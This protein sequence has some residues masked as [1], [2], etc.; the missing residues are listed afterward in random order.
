MLSEYLT[1]STIY[2][3]SLPSEVSAFVQRHVGVHNFTTDVQSNRAMLRHTLFG[4]LGL[5]VIYYGG[6]TTLENPVG[7]DSFHFQLVMNGECVIRVDGQ[8]KMLSAGC[9]MLMNPSVPSSV[10]Y[11]AD[12]TKLIVTI[13]P[14]LIS[15][16]SMDRSGNVPGEGVRFEP[17]PFAL[18]DRSTAFRTVELL[19]LEAEE[20]SRY[21]FIAN[22]ELEA[23]FI[24]K[25]LEKFPNNAAGSVQEPPQ[26]TRFFDSVDRFI[27]CHIE[28]DISAVAL[29]DLC[30]VSV[31]TLYQRF[32]LQKGVTPTAYV[33]DR[34]LRKAYQRLSNDTQVRSVSEIAFDYGFTHLGRFSAE[35]R[36]MFGELPSDTLRRTRAHCAWQSENCAKSG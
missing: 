16:C 9:A 30:N 25:M 18:N 21:P 17:L 10:T 32:T 15:A 5:S 3:D 27:D 35:F 24:G 33:K 29:A 31:R 8:E 23:L 13:P 36:A 34:K 12:C 4:N 2:Q 19:F 14:S 6:R 7:I 20:K 11:S 28:E 1:G 26:H 22:P